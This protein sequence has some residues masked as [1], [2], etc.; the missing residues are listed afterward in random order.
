MTELV[1]GLLAC[2]SKDY[3]NEQIKACEK[4]WCNSK[5]PIFY[6]SGEKCGNKICNNKVVH[7]KGVSDDVSSATYKQWYGLRWLYEHYPQ[8][9]YYYLAGTDTYAKLDKILE[10][11]KRL[12]QKIDTKDYLYIGG[13]GFIRHETG[14]EIYYHSG[15]PGFILSNS[16]MARIYSLIPKWIIQWNTNT[17]W[18][19]V[20]CDWSIACLFDHYKLPVKTIK[21]DNFKACNWKGCEKNGKKCCQN[22]N[23]DNIWVC[24]YMQPTD[25]IEFHNYLFKK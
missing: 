14:K 8:A 22:V 16:L 24:H 4:T 12:E 20:A 13:D 2:C 25:M 23:P 6:F 18:I 15:G 21:S 3:Y 11:L 17:H 19:K 7:L 10:F 5:I 9:K 1:V